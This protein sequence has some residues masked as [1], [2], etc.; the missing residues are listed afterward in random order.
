MP[1]ISDYR[2]TFRLLLISAIALV[3]VATFLRQTGSGIQASFYA[4]WLNGIGLTAETIGLL[5]GISNAVS[6]LAALTVG[7]LAGHVGEYWLLIV[8][9]GLAI[10]GIAFTPLIEGFILLAC[11]I[12]IRGAGQGVNLPM[13]IS[14]ASR[15]VPAR[16][17]GR[18]TALR[19]SFNRLGNAVFP[20]VMGA[21]AEWVGLENA[22]Y[23]VGIT[24]V[25]LLCVLSIWIAVRGSTP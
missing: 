1:R 15:S 10:V 5:I 13:M 25:G 2:E 23:I 8:S 21:L 4:V 11:A 24:G 18:V 14:I 7:R 6:A 3:I 17:Q 9:V 12:G 16:L 22:F 20:V 19:V